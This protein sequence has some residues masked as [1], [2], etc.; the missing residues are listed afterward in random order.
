MGQ[1]THLQSPAP[2]SVLYVFAAP[3]QMT[4][5]KSPNSLHQLTLFPRA[6]N[7]PKQLK[8][9]FKVPNRQ[10]EVLQHI[11]QGSRANELD[12]VPTELEKLG[13]LAGTEP[14]WISNPQLQ[15]P[16]HYPVALP[17]GR[18]CLGRIRDNSQ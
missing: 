5:V 12:R 14:E 4:P 9:S 10:S 15:I 18:I 2:F 17:N 6:C 13:K 11:A 7:L 3:V 8:S 1:Y 16:V